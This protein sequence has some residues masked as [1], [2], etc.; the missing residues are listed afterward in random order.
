[1]SHIGTLIFFLVT[2]TNM[3]GCTTSSISP[4]P[5]D[6]LPSFQ[7]VYASLGRTDIPTGS[8]VIEYL[9]VEKINPDRYRHELFNTL[10]SFCTSNG[11]SP[12]E[13][14][15]IEVLWAGGPEVASDYNAVLFFTDA[16]LRGIQTRWIASQQPI[17][18]VSKPEW[19]YL[20]NQFIA[21]PAE[22]MQGSRHRVPDSYLAFA[23]R[24]DGRRWDVRSTIDPQNGVH[25]TFEPVGEYLRS[26]GWCNM[27]N[28]VSGMMPERR[29]ET[30]DSLV[31]LT[32][33]TEQFNL[34]AI[35][36]RPKGP[37]TTRPASPNT[38]N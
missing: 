1:M 24:Y 32:L 17:Q 14:L 22:R 18:Y 29:L 9:A 19:A 25:G 31:H 30:W 6:R 20:I 34:K 7:S 35:K 36:E 15:L 27:L 23:S 3:L 5:E 37:P 26:L 11:I 2:T 4:S 28:A 10:R 8:S 33:Y 21:L 12:T 13:Y 16:D 38:A